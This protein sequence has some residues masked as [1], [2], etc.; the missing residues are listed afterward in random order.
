MIEGVPGVLRVQNDLRTAEGEVHILPDRE[1]LQRFGILPE[2]L[3]GT[4]QYGVRGFPLNELASGEREIP[5]II[6]FEG[7]DEQTL[8]ELRETPLFRGAAPRSRCPRSRTSASGAG[9]GEIRR[10]GG[11]ARA[12]SSSKPPRRTRASWRSAS[13]RSSRA[14]VLPQGFSYEDNRGADSTRRCSR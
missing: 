14:H 11:R 8:S 7:G 9:L 13:R 12:T 2:A 1:K 3:S 10:Q 5:L 4:V 6:Q